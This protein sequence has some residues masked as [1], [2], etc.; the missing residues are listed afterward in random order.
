MSGLFNRKLQSADK[1]SEVYAN[2]KKP[3][4][5]SCLGMRINNWITT[6]DIFNE[7]EKYIIKPDQLNNYLNIEFMDE[8][9]ESI[10]KLI[11]DHQYIYSDI[12]FYPDIKKLYENV[13]GSTPEKTKI[14]LFFKEQN[15][16]YS[17]KILGDTKNTKFENIDKI[18][19][20]EPKN[21]VRLFNFKKIS[22]CNI[23]NNILLEWD[24]INFYH[25]KKL[26]EEFSGNNELM[27]EGLI[28]KIHQK[29]NPKNTNFLNKSAYSGIRMYDNKYNY[30]TRPFFKY[31]RENRTKIYQDYGINLYV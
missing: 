3:E 12:Q 11:F 18:T 10:I 9:D 26:Y 28:K 20:S 1:I 8:N 19:G 21:K 2:I 15:N 25:I 14:Q 4:I 23:G 7:P 16:E 27:I 6:E 24:S 31:L 30:I 22:N 13:F 29:V 17:T 5:L